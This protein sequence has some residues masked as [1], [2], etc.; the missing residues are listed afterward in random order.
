[1]EV[2]EQ[3]RRPGAGHQ[4]P[5]REDQV[6]TGRRSNYDDSAFWQN[7]LSGRDDFRPERA[8]RPNQTRVAAQR[9]SRVAGQAALA[10]PA[11]SGGSEK[12]SGRKPAFGSPDRSRL[13][14]RAR[15]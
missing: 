13:R 14:R 12:L 2:L 11:D 1:P 9:P 6:A 10:Q 15:R 8:A 4:R 5:D 7:D 3:A